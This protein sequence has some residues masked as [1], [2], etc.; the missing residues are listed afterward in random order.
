MRISFFI[1]C[2]L[3]LNSV[4]LQAQQ[5]SGKVLDGETGESLIAA[6]IGILDSDRNQYKSIELT[7]VEGK[8]VINLQGDKM[9]RVQ[10][11]GFEELDISIDSI[12]VTKELVIALQ[13]ELTLLDVATISS[14]R[15]EKRLAEATVS[16]DVITPELITNSNG[17]SLDETIDKIPGVQMIE[18]QV[19][20]RGGSGYSY[21]AGSRV[22]LLVDD[23]PAL[24]GDAG[25]PNWNDLPV[26]NISQVEVIKGSA[27]VLYGSAALNGVINVRT[28]YAVSEPITKVSV[29][30]RHFMSPQDERKQ[31]WTESPYTVSTNILHKRKVKKLDVVFSSM[32]SSTNSIY[33]NSFTDRG[34]LSANLRYRFTDRT[35]LTLNTMYNKSNSA[36]FF[37]WNNGGV[38]AYQAF[39]GS[40]SERDSRR[41]YIDPVLTHF[42]KRG[43]KHKLLSRYYYI[44]NNN[45]NNQS[46]SSDNYYLEYQFSKNFQEKKLSITA[47]AT[48][49]HIVSDSEL[50]GDTLISSTNYSA[51]LQLE[52][53]FMDK[54][55]VSV[56]ARTENNKLRSPEEFLGI[57]VPGG[58]SKESNT[59]ARAGL[60]LELAKLS[61]LR[62]SFGQGYRFP[63][64]TEKFITTNFS[65]LIIFP[66]PELRSERGWTAE[67]GLKKGVKIS[68]FEGFVDLSIF[69]SQY[70]DMTEF[71]LA[72]ID[73]ISGFQSI[74][75]GDTD[76]KGFEIDIGTRSQIRNVPINITGG[77]TFIDPKYRDF[78]EQ[79]RQSSSEDINILKYRTRHNFK[80]DIEAFID[81][82]SVGLAYNYT[83]RIVAIDGLLNNIGFIDLYRRNN[84]DGFQKIDARIGYKY[85]FAKFSILL[86]NV[87]NEEYTLRPGLLAAPRNL[88]LRLDFD[89]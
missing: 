33:E 59:V 1:I 14:S 8:F 5:L 10:Y 65:G 2:L 40:E 53:K 55:T 69:W 32:L 3:T 71:T 82:F 23:M 20:I 35:N 37:I 77:Y 56:G 68:S 26:E 24:Q 86:N 15:Y 31:W 60:N 62:A 22:L 75:V 50:F 30:Y 17:Q 49:Y 70:Q 84:N 54:L 44:E 51:Y 45:N 46:N 29:A 27:S 41:Y 57:T 66:N 25:R 64:I 78:T 73:G 67:I 34:R 42:D 21:G 39:P 79:I 6:T 61:F 52:K 13:A 74:N 72:N 85:K 80:I 43:N 4:L 12:D 48:Y 81:N 19:N 9:V 76:I 47:G 36:D 89:L 83:S 18:G 63:T 16:I 88:S 38:G 87:L 58:L 7:D 28:G 11:V